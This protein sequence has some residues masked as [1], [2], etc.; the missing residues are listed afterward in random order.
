MAE[1][2]NVYT[3]VKLDIAAHLLPMPCARLIADAYALRQH[4][5]NRLQRQSASVILGTRG[6]TVHCENALPE[7]IPSEALASFTTECRN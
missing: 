4:P 6:W 3:V 2:L 1:C 5:Q 7:S